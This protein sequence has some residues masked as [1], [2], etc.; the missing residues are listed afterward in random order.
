MKRPESRIPRRSLAAGAV[1]W[2]GA[3]CVGLFAWSSAAAGGE[4]PQQTDALAQGALIYNQ[5]RLA[6]GA[7]LTG[8]RAGQ[9]PVV[10]SD[11]A[12]ANCHR[13]SGLG[14]VEGDEH[15][16]PVAGNFLFAPRGAQG[17][18]TMDPRVSKSFNR[19]H[20]PYT[21]ESLMRAVR[22]GINSQGQP[23]GVLMPRYDL[24]ETALNALA[25]H[26]RQLSTHWSPGVTGTQ[27]SLATVI[28]PEVD[29]PGAGRSSR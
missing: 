6:T 27:I 25:A 15:V 12:C 20:D 21:D 14:Q 28:T 23:L 3:L 10:G 13:P 24:D 18:L 26:L 4:P 8:R 17:V 2:A 16:P 29:A 19:A 9:P 7:P 5:G 1:Q 22:D 11:A